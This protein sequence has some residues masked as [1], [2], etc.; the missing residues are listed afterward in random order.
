MKFFFTNAFLH[1]RIVQK[2]LQTMKLTTLFLLLSLMQVSATVYSQATKFN[3]KAENKQIADVLK[4]IEESSDFRFFYIREQVDVERQVSLSATNSTIEEIL[5]EI[6]QDQKVIYQVMDDNA[7]LLRPETHKLHSQKEDQQ[8]K[9]VSGK[10]TDSGGAPLPG[11]TIVLKGTA[12]GTVSNI[13]GVFALQNIPENATLVFSFVGMKTQEVLIE[14]TAPLNIVMEENAIGVD[15]VVVVGYGTQK[16][17]NLTGAVGAISSEELA[18]RP[19]QNASQMLQGLVPGLNISQSQGGSLNRTP[20]IN[21]RGLATIGEGS[22]GSPLILIDGVEGDINALNPQ[23]IDNI[24]VLKDAAASSIYGSRAPFGVILITTK[25]GVKGKTTINYNNSARWSKPIR[26]PSMMDSYTFAYYVNDTRINSGE[27]GY[28]SEE[29]IQRIIDFQNGDIS[30]GTVEDPRNPSIWGNGWRVGNDNIDWYDEYY[31]DYTFS[32]EHTIS[33]S[34]G[35]DK[36]QFYFSGNYLDQGG[37]LNYGQEDFNRYATTLKVNAELNSWLSVSVKNQFTREDYSQPTFLDNA[38]FQ[39]IALHGWPTYSLND[40]NGYTFSPWVVNLRDGGRDKTQSDWLYQQIGF[41]LEPIK[42][43]TTHFELN[44][45]TRNN[46]R[47]FDR[48]YTYMHDV[49]GSPYYQNSMS[50]VY[51]YA[52]RQNFLTTNIYTEYEK[53]LEAGHNFK[54]LIGFQAEDSKYKKL[55]AQRNGII[56]PALPV[57]N[58][59]SGTDSNGNVVTPSVSGYTDSWSTS[60]FF[61]RLNYDYQGRYLLEANLRYDGTSRFRKDMRWNW[62]PSVSAGWNIAKESF[63]QTIEDKISTMKLRAS[64]GE[65]GN[66]NTSNIYPTYLTMGVY[67]SSGQWLINGA[68]PNTA[69][70]PGLISQSMTWE[71][72]HSWNF[73]LDMALFDN[74]LNTSFD[75]FIRKTLD[76]IGPAPELPEILGTDVPKTNN[77]DLKTYGFELSVSWRDRLD[78]GLGY[79]VQFLLSDSQ[80]EITRYPNE[81]GNLNTYRKGMKMGEIW[82]YETIGIAKSQEEMDAHLASLPNGGQNAVGST[83]GQWE[84]GDIMYKD[85]NNDGKIDNGAETEGNHGDW[86]IIGNSTPRYQF[87]LDL[88]ANWKNFDIRAL[89]QGVMKRD[90]F[91][92]S[93]YFWG[94]YHWGIWWS[95]GLDQHLDYFR[96]ESS[97]SYSTLGENLDAYYPRPSYSDKNH[98]SQ[99]RYLQDASYIRLKNLQVGYT[100]PK[101]IY[102]KLGMSQLRVFVSGENLWTGTK[103]TSIFDPESVEAG[104]L[105][106]NGIGYGGSTYPIPK[107]FSVGVNVNF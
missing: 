102:T 79:S 38:F 53:Q 42:N 97:A 99:T 26:M 96:D 65:L 33:A 14:G 1:N 20:D 41:R 46:L 19:V 21:I 7:I 55:S 44:Y 100:L 89:F 70:A 45:R 74:R 37:F 98:E 58:L 104:A 80:T 39:Q 83:I 73:G 69:V 43:W 25:Q 13:D 87:S 30:Y 63:W 6:F 103:M 15:E 28:F 94:A 51:E 91:Q 52:M 105:G 40:P 2:V 76:M 23:D 49:E 61:G 16:K 81:T 56:V 9:S 107:V 85:L 59:T 88:T 71:R 54:G 31:R 34:G 60:G 77:T 12:N 95:T 75:Y 64:Y 84:A 67:A 106:N 10:V 27:T 93:N 29:R 72:I 50:E 32:Q 62:F 3:F 86:K 24:S 22:T 17:I 8:Q 90:Y 47:H 57:I 11:V 92:N 101:S 36:M 35:S 18:E 48:Q 68:K 78:N 4:E 82:G 5:D 66:Q